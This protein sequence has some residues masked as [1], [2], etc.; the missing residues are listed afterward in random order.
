[1]ASTAAT[2]SRTSRRAAAA[3]AN[4]AIKGTPTASNTVTIV[5]GARAPARRPAPAPDTHEGIIQALLR[6]PGFGWEEDL[7]W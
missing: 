2:P 1:M 7:T 4:A 6:L 5:P 3:A